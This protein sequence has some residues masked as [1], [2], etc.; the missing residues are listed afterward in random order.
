MPTN[1][2]CTATDPGPG[3]ILDLQYNFNLGAGDNG[4]V[5]GIT[6]NRDTTRTQSFTYDAVNRIVQAQTSSTSGSNC[7]GEIYTIDEWANL[8]NIAA[9]SGYG[10]CTQESGLSASPTVKNQLS[11]TGFSYDAAGNMLTDGTNT[12]AYNA[13]SEIKSAAS[14]NYTYDGDG[15]R[16]EK[17]SGTI[18]WYGAGTEILDESNTSGTLRN[19]KEQPPK[20]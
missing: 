17:S 10:A 14:V 7:W 11:A 5:A 9:L 20:R 16:L 12:Y 13:E 15:N 3:N 18:Y 1:T 2:V 6:N 4:N 8:S 19:E